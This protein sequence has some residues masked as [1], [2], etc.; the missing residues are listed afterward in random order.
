MSDSIATQQAPAP[1][2]APEAAGQPVAPQAA[3]PTTQSP[4]SQ[5]Y[6]PNQVGQRKR[7]AEQ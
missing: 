3:A 5:T 1:Q 4:G 7:Q 6:D 2:P